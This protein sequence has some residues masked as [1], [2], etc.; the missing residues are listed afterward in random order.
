MSKKSFEEG[1]T[2][3]IKTDMTPS[4]RTSR[5]NRLEKEVVGEVTPKETKTGRR[6]VE[7]STPTKNENTTPVKRPSRTNT[8]QKP[9][10]GE[11]VS[12]GTP[13]ET[14]NGGKGK[15]SSIAR[16]RV[17][18][19]V[20]REQQKET[21]TFK[22]DS[23]FDLTDMIDTKAEEVH[24]TA[25]KEAKNGGIIKKSLVE[26]EVDSPQQEIKRSKQ[27]QAN[28][29]PITTDKQLQ[30]NAV[31]IQQKVSA[32]QQSAAIMNILKSSKRKS[33]PEGGAPP[34]K[35]TKLSDKNDT[36][37]KEVMETKSS[38]SD[39]DLIID[40]KPE[41]SART[42]N[43]IVD[44]EKCI[45]PRSSRLSRNRQ[46]K[47]MNLDPPVTV[48]PDTKTPI[49]NGEGTPKRSKR[50][51]DSILSTESVE[52]VKKA[53]VTPKRMKP[54]A[55]AKT[56]ATSEKNKLSKTPK[57]PRTPKVGIENE[58]LNMKANIEK[59]KELQKQEISLIQKEGTYVQC[60]RPECGLWRLVT[61]YHDPATVPDNWT[62]SMNPDPEAR[63][64]GLG[65]EKV[66][67][68]ETVDVE[69]TCGSMVWA[70][71]KGFPSWPGMVDYCPD[72]Q[73]HINLPLLT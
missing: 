24:E 42:D 51:I 59:I 30:E 38:E 35:E 46:G 43:E 66:E 55:S 15:K 10:E 36:K 57:T 40:S 41:T 56:S 70:K 1:S 16:N 32:Q 5:T 7:E 26:N 14:K 61:E 54:E 68:E 37:S 64:C 31:Q 69:Y 29:S 20:N 47:P 25:K 67:D 11:S 21:E 60:S 13:K 50:R 72:T 58:K 27:L 65:G 8:V 19:T 53:K 63:I 3:T 73:V 28:I 44:S 48:T 33:R 2:P 18:E 71:L 22:I 39:T 12:N 4:K 9:I 17:K 34:A 49:Q 23:Q 62:C 6:M 52:S 45:T